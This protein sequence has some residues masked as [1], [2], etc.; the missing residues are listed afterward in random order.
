MTADQTSR[1]DNVFFTHKLSK[2]CNFFPTHSS[3]FVRIINYLA[4]K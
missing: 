4:L 3:N 1:P 2:D